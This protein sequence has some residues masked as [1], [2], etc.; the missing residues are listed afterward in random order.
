MSDQSATRAT[1]VAPSWVRWTG[2]P[3]AALAALGIGLTSR[4][5]QRTAGF[6]VAAAG[7]VLWAAA[8]LLGAI[9]VRRRDQ[10]VPG[11]VVV[12]RVVIMLV[13]TSSIIDAVPALQVHG[14]VLHGADFL[15]AA[16]CG[17]AVG[18]VVT[19]AIGRFRQS[20]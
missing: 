11:W 12:T 20:G 9:R 6:I 10:Q 16:L 14:F 4:H 13:V 17:M 3:L 5:D 15:A 1:L 18:C 8:V 7:A 19:W 2:I